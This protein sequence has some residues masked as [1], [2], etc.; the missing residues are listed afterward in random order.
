MQND[1][2]LPA[3]LQC[4]DGTRTRHGTVSL[5]SPAAGVG[6][7]GLRFVPLVVISVSGTTRAGRMQYAPTGDVLVHARQAHTRRRGVLHTP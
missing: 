5:R 7:S 2:L 4:T 1:T 3:N 6:A